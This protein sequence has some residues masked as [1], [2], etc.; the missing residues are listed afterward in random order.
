MGDLAGCEIGVRVE[1]R[2]H[3]RFVRKVLK[4]LGFDLRHCHI[5]IAPRGKGSGEQWVRQSYVREVKLFRK[6][7]KGIRPNSGLLAVLDADTVS[8][9]GRKTLLDDEL[10]SNGQNARNSNEAIAI[11]VPKRHIETWL[12]HLCGA[13]VTEEVDVK[14]QRPNVEISR[15]AIQFV[16]LFHERKQGSLT[17]LPSNDSALMETARIRK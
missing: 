14:R 7:K 1:D 6:R 3:E 2:H 17:T 16:R 10:R 11:W 15:A 5:K 12:L 4:E 9:E 13:D 8:V